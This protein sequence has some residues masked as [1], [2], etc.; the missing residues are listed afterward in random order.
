MLVPQKIE[1]TYIIDLSSSA[2]PMLC[3]GIMLIVRFT[4]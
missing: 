3:I 4:V 2:S 1:V